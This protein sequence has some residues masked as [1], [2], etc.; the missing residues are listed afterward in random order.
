MHVLLLQ[1][2][3]SMPCFNNNIAV[4]SQSCFREDIPFGDLGDSS[5]RFPNLTQAI[6]TS[7]QFQCCGDITAWQTCVEPSGRNHRDGVYSIIFQVWRPS[8]SVDIDGCYA[9]VGEDRYEDIQ[10][11]ESEG[12]LVNRILNPSSFISVQPGDVLGYF[13]FLDNDEFEDGG[14]QHNPEFNMESVWY[15]TNTDDDPLVSRGISCTL[16]VG[17]G[18]DRIL[19]TFSSLGPVFSVDIGK[20]N[21]S[22]TNHFLTCNCV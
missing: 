21:I 19:R 6:V 8:P 16:P 1:E 4:M 22:E 3:Y 12:G 17:E 15:H 7:Y 10:L 2:L 14:I 11:I 18:T 5:M 9:I 20:Y 13:T